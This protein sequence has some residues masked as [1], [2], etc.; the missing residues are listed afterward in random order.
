MTRFQQ[1]LLILI[2]F[3]SIILQTR[4]ANISDE[5]LKK[6]NLAEEVYTVTDNKNILND[7]GEEDDFLG[8]SREAQDGEEVPM[9]RSVSFCGCYG[10][11]SGS[12]TG[13][14]GIMFD[15]IFSETLDGYSFDLS[16]NDE[17]KSISD[18]LEYETEP[19]TSP[20]DCFKGR[21][22]TKYSMEWI[23]TIFIPYL[24]NGN[25]LLPE[26]WEEILNLVEKLFINEAAIYDISINFDEEL[27]VV[28]DIHGQMDDL[29]RIFEQNG[30]P[31][32][33]RKFIFNGDIID[34]GSN[35]I[36][37]LMTLFLMKIYFPSSVFITRGNH[38]S[39]TCGEGTFKEE[40]FERIKESLKFFVKCHDIFNVLPIGYTIQDRF[41]VNWSIL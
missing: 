17:M 35:S 2:V 3:L 34:R 36:G 14:G 26:T 41:F 16:F 1:E 20:Q 15:S 30:F 32:L 18:E 27:I 9:M 24:Q 37:C 38:E 23:E 6:S 11:S 22:V 28:G 4:A 33:N 39:H 10:S 5:Q 31:S 8:H 19:L 29:V 7:F 40:C 25:Q 21:A 13:E 12:A